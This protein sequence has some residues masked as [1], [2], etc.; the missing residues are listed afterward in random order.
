MALSALARHQMG[1]PVALATGM[2]C[3]LAFTLFDWMPNSSA[4]ADYAARRWLLSVDFVA[5]SALSLGI[6]AVVMVAA[7]FTRG[8]RRP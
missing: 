7:V 5:L 6:V 8:R 4:I 3:L 1:L 2:A